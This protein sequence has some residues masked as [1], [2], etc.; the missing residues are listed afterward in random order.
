LLEKIKKIKC[1][2]QENK[3]FL[4]LNI[5]IL[6]LLFLGMT[7]ENAPSILVSSLCVSS[8]KEFKTN[9]KGSNSKLSE[10]PSAKASVG[11]I[12]YYFKD[13]K[14]YVLLG[15]ER[16]DSN[17]KEKAGK[18]ADF[19]GSVE[20]N[21]TTFAHNAI[22]ELKEET[23]SQIILHEKELIK[24]GS[25]LYKK[26]ATGREIIY[27]FYPLSKRQYQQAK[28]LNSLWPILC[29]HK[30]DSVYCE[31][32]QFVWL[33]LQDIVNQEKFVRDLNEN[34]KI[35]IFREFFTKDCIEH[36]D[37]PI[38]LESIERF[39]QPITVLFINKA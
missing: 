14:I 23:M 5:I 10:I 21:N 34:R 8:S 22:R 19:G 7:A 27:I 37:L 39:N 38:L 9:F 25:L 28:V 29:S 4:F 35:I 12:L 32:D 13:E 20:L 31:K 18:F 26:S 2:F 3:I 30:K 36:P 17:K 33:N 24:K 6:G 15:R 16:I 11:I 1:F